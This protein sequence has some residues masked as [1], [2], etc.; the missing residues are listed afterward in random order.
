[1]FE[2]CITVQLPQEFDGPHGHDEPSFLTHGTTLLTMCV[3]P[4]S[5]DNDTC[6]HG[7]PRAHALV[8]TVP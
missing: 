4:S 3:F 8:E 2:A 5:R 6:E 7:L 1:M